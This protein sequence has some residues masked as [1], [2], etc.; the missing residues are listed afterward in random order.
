MIEHHI[1]TVV[2]ADQILVLDERKLV[3]YGIHEQLM[4]RKSLYHK[5]FTI[6]QESLGWT[7]GSKS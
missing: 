7:V 4:N 1:R 6:Q 5:M 3:E 2:D